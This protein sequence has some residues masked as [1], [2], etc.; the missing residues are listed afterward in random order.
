MARSADEEAVQDIKDPKARKEAYYTRQRQNASVGSST[1]GK[2]SKKLGWGGEARAMGKDLLQS[3]MASGPWSIPG[4]KAAEAV[5]GAVGGAAKALGSGASRLAKRAGGAIEEE[6]QRL[7]TPTPVKR[8]L[9]KGQVKTSSGIHT[10]K[11][12]APAKPSALS[13]GHNR[14]ITSSTH[15][16]A[17]AS[18]GPRLTGTNSSQ[19]ALGTSGQWHYEKELGKQAGR[20]LPK[21]TSK[22]EAHVARQRAKGGYADSTTGDWIHPSESRAKM[23]A[24]PKTFNR[25]GTKRAE[26]RQKS[27]RNPVSARAKPKSTAKSK[28]M[29]EWSQ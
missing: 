12:L 16:G 20:K 29:D 17:K 26:G 25:N 24:Q 4:G 28:H 5:E 2:I 8:A 14:A 11:G 23:P 7:R 10:Q 19:K 1:A 9:G 18:T 21:D 13:T 6:V 15:P 22:Q 3:R 27:D